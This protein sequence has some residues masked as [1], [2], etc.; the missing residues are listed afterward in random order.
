LSSD[1]IPQIPSL[2]QKYFHA[3]SLL[4]VEKLPEIYTPPDTYA[5]KEDYSP[6]PNTYV[7][8]EPEYHPPKKYVPPEPEQLYI[9]PPEKY[10]P[11]PEKYSPPREKYAPPPESYAPPPEK[12]APPP[13]NY[14]PPPEKYVPPPVNYAPG[15]EKYAPPPPS[16]TPKPY[17]PPATYAFLDEYGSPAP[18]PVYTPTTLYTPPDDYR[19]PA[20]HQVSISSMFK[21][22]YMRSDPKSTKKTYNLTNYFVVLGSSRVKA[23]HKM[24]MKLTPGRSRF[25]TGIFL[26]LIRR[27]NS[28]LNRSEI[29]TA[30]AKSSDKFEKKSCSGSFVKTTC[31]FFLTKNDIERYFV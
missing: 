14:A 3:L 31:K 13:E 2:S 9:P 16:Y 22:S 20:A 27:S 28:Q 12:Y 10:A 6:P 29:S 11:P 15:A 24:L 19:P 7:P 8:P 17:T 23:A 26:Q 1:N 5:P 18:K 21:H 4:N 30:T 25:F